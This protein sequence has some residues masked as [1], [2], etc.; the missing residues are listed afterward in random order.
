MAGLSPNI[1]GPSWWAVLHGL[2]HNSPASTRPRQWA[3]FIWNI[4]HV[5]PCRVCRE[6]FR[7]HLA[8]PDHT[9]SRILNKL[10]EDIT[11]GEA[12]EL[13]FR[14]HN[15]VRSLAALKSGVPCT[16]AV[17]LEELARRQQLK[18][19]PG[20]SRGELEVVLL[21]PALSVDLGGT[22]RPSELRAFY[23]SLAA[24][25][26]TVPATATAGNALRGAIM[27]HWDP[28]RVWRSVVQCHKRM[29]DTESGKQLRARMLAASSTSS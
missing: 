28:T 10:Q 15:R 26:L 27:T 11:A 16:R 23:L 3:E 14:L 13:L 12:T 22:I 7:G 18:G 29:F 5:L 6:H 21:T 24:V 19:A 20:F 9:P 8:P 17:T 1:W 2:A 25:L 4:Q